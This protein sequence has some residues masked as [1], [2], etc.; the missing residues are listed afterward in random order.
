MCI[1]LTYACNDTASSQGSTTF[2]RGKVRWTV[3]LD[4]SGHQASYVFVGVSRGECVSAS[5]ARLLIP[6]VT[7]PFSPPLGLPGAP[8]QY[9][10]RT[11]HPPDVPL[12]CI[13]VLDL[14]WTASP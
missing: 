8:C 2:Q 14:R 1:Y 4:N 5:P 7:S 12:G 13:V 11:V 3:Q 9:F 10:P 6:G